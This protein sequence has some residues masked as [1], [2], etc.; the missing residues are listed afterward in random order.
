MFQGHSSQLAQTESLLVRRQL[1]RLYPSQLRCC[2]RL[3][4]PRQNRSRSPPAVGF[5]FLNLKQPHKPRRTVQRLRFQPQPYRPP[6]NRPRYRRSRRVMMLYRQSPNGHPRSFQ[7]PRQ[8][9]CR[10]Q[11]VTQAGFSGHSS[12]GLRLKPRRLF[13]CRCH[14][15]KAFSK[16]EPMAKSP[17]FWNACWTMG[18]T[19]TGHT[20]LRLADL[21]W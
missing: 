6:R 20:G 2:R 14:G 9:V 19:L 10:V 7:K 1:S 18:N 3:P 17:T 5:R 12:R 15:S 13:V 11:P 21:R 4:I 16:N 8:E